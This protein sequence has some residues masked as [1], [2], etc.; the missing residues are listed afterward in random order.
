M[1]QPSAERTAPAARPTPFDLLV[2]SR[3][4]LI[5]RYNDRIPA[6]R[7]ALSEIGQEASSDQLRRD[8]LSW[9]KDLPANK[10]ALLDRA[11]QLAEKLGRSDADDWHESY[12]TGYV[13]D[14]LLPMFEAEV[15]AIAIAKGPAN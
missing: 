7:A 12:T 10:N 1:S 3:R 6:I 8:Y 14:D 4:P 11:Y 2:D 5:S 15:A 9:I 13:I